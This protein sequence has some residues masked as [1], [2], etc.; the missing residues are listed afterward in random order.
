MRS[1]NLKSEASIMLMSDDRE[2][3]AISKGFERMKAF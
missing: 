1:G 3:E 2:E